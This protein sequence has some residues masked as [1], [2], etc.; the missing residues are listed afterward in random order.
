MTDAMPYRPAGTA[1]SS[2]RISCGR[3]HATGG[4][5]RP[6]DPSAAPTALA[7]FPAEPQPPLRHEAERAEDLVRW[8]EFDR[9]GHFTALEGPDLPVE[10]ARAFFRESPGT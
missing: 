4:T 6:A 10:E 5:A 3:A 2:A 9:G 7:L 1:G 8:T